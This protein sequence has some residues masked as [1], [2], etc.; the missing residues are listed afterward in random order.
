MGTIMYFYKKTVL[1]Y[2]CEGV[3]PVVGTVIVKH[4]PLADYNKA[5]IGLLSIINNI[6]LSLLYSAIGYTIS[7]QLC[8]TSKNQSLLFAAIIASTVCASLFTFQLLSF[9]IRSFRHYSTQTPVSKDP[10]ED[11]KTST[12]HE[13][14]KQKDTESS[15][16][17][18]PYVEKDRGAYSDLIDSQ[19]TLY[20]DVMRDTGLIYTV[21][22]LGLAPVCTLI[23][24]K[25]VKSFE[26]S[27]C[28]TS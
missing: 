5:R 4:L 11:T 8:S 18:P 24:C 3:C 7:K 26:P 16:G 28:V 25:V 14:P 20:L 15:A 12:T 13:E 10:R 19:E 17:M 23:Q 22:T 2:S 21:L 1:E 27:L 9:G 6:V